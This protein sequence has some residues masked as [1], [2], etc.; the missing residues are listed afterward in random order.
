MRKQASVI[1]MAFALVALL[2]GCGGGSPTAT[3]APAAG[4]TEPVA[5]AAPPAA[6]ATKVVATRAPA[7]QPRADSR[8]GLDQ[9]EILC[10]NTDALL[11]AYLKQNK[12]MTDLVSQFIRLQAQYKEAKTTQEKARVATELS[13][14][15]P[16]IGLQW[17]G[18]QWLVVNKAR[19]DE[20]INMSALQAIWTWAAPYAR[21][22][23]AL[24]GRKPRDVTGKGLIGLDMGMVRAVSGLVADGAEEARLDEVEDILRKAAANPS[25]MT[26]DDML[27]LYGFQTRYVGA[28]ET[29]AGLKRLD[30]KVEDG[31]IRL[32]D[33]RKFSVEK[34]GVSEKRFSATERYLIYT[35][36]GIRMFVWQVVD[37]G[38]YTSAMK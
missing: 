14:L 30:E 26:T 9:L 18:K 1:W 22:F 4:I 16:K 15:G 35:E 10:A 7:T 17:D 28:L 20:F 19:Y 12:E 5:T 11:Y 33:G 25:S 8:S 23:L 24:A 37:E 21:G 2:A 3:R 6:A 13:A 34:K 32:P 36:D 31:Q 29:L 38:K 27:T